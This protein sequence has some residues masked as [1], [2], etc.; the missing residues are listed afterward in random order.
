ML[1]G[2]RGCQYRMTSYDEENGG[3]DFSPTYGIQLHDPRMLEYVGVPELAGLL[4]HSLEY[5]LHHLGLEKTL[6]AALQLQHDTG[7]I[8]SNERAGAAPIRHLT[9]HEVVGGHEGRIRS[10]AVSG[11]CNATGGAIVPGSSG[12]TLYGGSGLVA[13]TLYTGNSGTPAVGDMQCL[14]VVQ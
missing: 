11:G 3:P 5:W 14:H 4:S 10:G 9:Q 12:G 6:A 13:A 7:L 2:M 1:D 8:L